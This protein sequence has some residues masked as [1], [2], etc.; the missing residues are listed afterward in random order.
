MEPFEERHSSGSLVNPVAPLDY[1]IIDPVDCSGLHLGPGNIDRRGQT[2]RQRFVEHDTGKTLD[3]GFQD[4][5]TRRT[6]KGK[7]NFI[8]FNAFGDFVL[9]TGKGEANPFLSCQKRALREFLEEGGSWRR[10]SK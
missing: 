3:T 7:R 6:S 1:Q 8:A 10:Q 5:R 4:V 9:R 2:H